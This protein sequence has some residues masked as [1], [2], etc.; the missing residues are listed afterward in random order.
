MHFL[1]LSLSA[2]L[3]LGLVTCLP[4]R[5]QTAK[6]QKA[7]KAKF[8]T[9]DGVKLEGLFYASSK[10]RKAP[11]A[12]LLHRYGGKIAE[13]GWETLAQALQDKGF[14]VLAFDSRGH[15]NSTDVDES[16]WKQYSY[17]RQLLGVK[18]DATKPPE[19]IAHK[20][21]KAGYAPYLLNDIAAAKAY[22]ERR[23]DNGDCNV[24]NL[25]LIGAEE[26]G[27]LGLAWLASEALRYRV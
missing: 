20:D 17:N 4:A 25:V 1:N 22:L 11:C 10:G 5:A 15:G 14:A 16:F 23:N 9:V 27:A 26:G 18:F 3:A 8:E 21:F 13:D 7:E 12:I 24:S 6:E 2:C 19:K